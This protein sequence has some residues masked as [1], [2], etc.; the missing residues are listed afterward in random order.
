MSMNK[1]KPS[2]PTLSTWNPEMAMNHY[3]NDAMCEMFEDK[4]LLWLTST[5]TPHSRIFNANIV[6]ILW[7]LIH[8]QKF[9]TL[10]KLVLQILQK[11]NNILQKNPLKFNTSKKP[12]ISCQI[13][14]MWK[15]LISFPTSTQK[16]T[17]QKSS[18]KDRYNVHIGF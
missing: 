8:L 12:I 17:T 10:G 16:W 11:F 4:L 3:K 5:Y 13:W 15:R 2:D 1:S 18:S 7:T 14:L 6:S 9:T